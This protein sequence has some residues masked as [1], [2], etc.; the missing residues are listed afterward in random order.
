M[1]VLGSLQLPGT[2]VM[3]AHNHSP[4]THHLQTQVPLKKSQERAWTLHPLQG[5]FSG[6][7][8]K[9]QLTFPHR[10][11]CLKLIPQLLEAVGARRQAVIFLQLIR[12]FM[13]ES[14]WIHYR[15]L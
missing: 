12:T 10:I 8:N 5:G 2:G 6:S 15:I 11:N 4:S 3:S 14:I 9:M 7:L 13:L 1:H